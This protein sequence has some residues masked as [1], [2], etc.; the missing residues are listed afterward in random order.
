MV[1][2]SIVNVATIAAILLGAEAGPCRPTTTGVTSLAE[3]SSMAD[4]TYLETSSAVAS[5]ST[6]T[7]LDTTTV[8]TLAD[9][10]TTAT[11]FDATTVATATDTTTTTEAEST[12][13]S[14]APGCIETELLVNPG[15]DDS[16][17]T[18]TPWTSPALL[19]KQNTQSGPNALAFV[20]RNGG[21]YDFSVKQ[22]L[23]N[24]DGYYKFSYYYRVVSASLFADYTCGLTINIGD[25]TIIAD[26]DYSVGG[27]K[28]GSQNW[29]SQGEVAQADVKLTINCGGE[30]DQVQVNV[31]SFSFTQV[32]DA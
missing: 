29:N 18:I 27:W 23:S 7:S 2:L 15:F 31:D 5:E 24:L 9:T 19:V 3:T 14:A 1:R 20:Y 4:A 28:L 25:T 10:T 11:S 21:G 13:T 32:C 22:T 30:F 26:M 6:T 8:T 17:N 16:P 12:T